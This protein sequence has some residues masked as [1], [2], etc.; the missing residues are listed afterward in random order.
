M[1]DVTDDVAFAIA[2][3]PVVVFAC[4]TW[5]MHDARV[6]HASLVSGSLVRSLSLIE[7]RCEKISFIFFM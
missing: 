7:Y 2:C 5:R 4:V 3:R 6:A 1:F